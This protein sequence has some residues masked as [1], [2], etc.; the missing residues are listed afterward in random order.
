MTSQIRQIKKRW[1]KDEGY[2]CIRLPRH[3]RER[4]CKSSTQ[5]G[6]HQGALSQK[7][8]KLMVFTRIQAASN[9]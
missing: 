5:N 8:V 1:R 9:K 3:D 7:I 6:A 2:R 4:S